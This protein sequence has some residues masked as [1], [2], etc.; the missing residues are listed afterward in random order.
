MSQN[1]NNWDPRVLDESSTDEVECNKK[2]ASGKMG[3]DAI[4]FMVNA[5]SLQLECTRVLHKSLLVPVLMYGSVVGACSYI[6]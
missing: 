5:R 6:W 4:R 3:A 1:L 2:V